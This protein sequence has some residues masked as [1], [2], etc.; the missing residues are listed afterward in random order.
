MKGM[1]DLMEGRNGMSKQGQKKV[2]RELE[3]KRDGRKRGRRNK[4]NQ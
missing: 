1:R 3:R 2:R 4:N